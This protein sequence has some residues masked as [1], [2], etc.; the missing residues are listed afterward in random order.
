MN[1]GKRIRRY[2]PGSYVLS[3]LLII[4]ILVASGSGLYIWMQKNSWEATIPYVLKTAI[5]SE[6]AQEVQDAIPVTNI[7]RVVTQSI[8]VRSED[9]DKICEELKEHV[10][11]YIEFVATLMGIVISVMCVVV[12]LF[13]Y[14][15]VQKETVDKLKDYHEASDYFKQTYVLEGDLGDES[16]PVVLLGGIAVLTAVGAVA[17]H[18]KRK[19]VR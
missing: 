18:R 13:N 3:F 16:I 5:V 19:S 6:E 17:V 4:I 14:V 10:D 7:R 9:I 1:K 15:F 2:W 8:E 12:P 11:D